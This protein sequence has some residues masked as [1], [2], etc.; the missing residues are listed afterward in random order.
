MEPNLRSMIKKVAIDIQR[1]INALLFVYQVE[2]KDN[3][4]IDNLYDNY[5]WL[6]DWAFIQEF[7]LVKEGFW[8]KQ[9]ILQYIYHHNK[10]RDWQKIE[11]KDQKFA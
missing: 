6:Q 4:L 9:W 11:T 2:S 3:K 10:N 1:T 7:I 8:L 5:I